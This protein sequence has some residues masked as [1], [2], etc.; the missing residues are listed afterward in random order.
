MDSL[1]YPAWAP[2]PRRPQIADGHV[3]VWR[4]D[5]TALEDALDRQLLALL[6]PE[7]RA[8]AA[9]FARASD[10]RLWARARVVLRELLGRYTDSDPRA[11][12]F[13]TG[14]YGK[15]ALAPAA[16][17]AAAVKMDGLA[18]TQG[19]QHDSQ[20]PPCF[21]LAHSGGLALYAIGDAGNAV[22]VDVER[23][24]RQ[25]DAVAIAER[26]F[27]RVEAERLQ[28]LDGEARQREFLRLWVRHEAESKCW[29]TGLLQTPREAAEGELW[30]AELELGSQGAGVVAAER[31]PQRLSCWEYAGS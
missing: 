10:G 19:R 4:A 3:H 7:E 17:A 9:G 29:G 22:G 24:R 16:T 6:S 27:G 30:T 21:N 11:L 1:A 20:P 14:A 26:V 13:V 2:A 5:L 23:G 18:L 8:R 12:R 15:P 28:A 31:P 25:I